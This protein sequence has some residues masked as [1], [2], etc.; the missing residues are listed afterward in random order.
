MVVPTDEAVVVLFSVEV[1]IAVVV[2]MEVP[3]VPLFVESV[4][5]PLST[6]ELPVVPLASDKAVA[7]LF[8]S[9]GPLPA[10]AASA[11]ISAAINTAVTRLFISFTTLRF[12]QSIQLY[13]NRVNNATLFTSRRRGT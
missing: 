1:D 11:S 3:V 2:S 12:F 7:V 4:A 8:S 5:M 10:Q 13:Y 6:D 9:I